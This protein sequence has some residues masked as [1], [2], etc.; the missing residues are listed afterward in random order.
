MT[1]Y[2]PTS[3][4][5]RTHY[6]GFFDPGFGHDADGEL[7]GSRAALEVRAHDVPFMVEHG[8]RVCK[9]TFE[10]MLCRPTRLYGQDIGSHYQGQTRTLG[11]HFRPEPGASG[12][13]ARRTAN[14]AQPELFTDLPTTSQLCLPVTGKGRSTPG[15]RHQLRF[16]GSGPS[17]QPITGPDLD[18][19]V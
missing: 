4:E 6:A 13:E 16:H 8:Q 15:W 19:L 12:P 7:S 10:R 18:P 5:L 1:A 14:L 9:L 17:Q 11:K 2:D 3:G